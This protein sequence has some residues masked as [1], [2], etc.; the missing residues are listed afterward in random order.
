MPFRVYI[1]M[2][3]M[4]SNLLPVFLATGYLVAYCILLRAEPAIATIMLLFSP[5]VVC[6]MVYS[7]LKFARY[8]GTDLGDEEYGYQDKKKEEL[9]TF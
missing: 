6:G 4:R 9:G 1:K 5:L 8:K 3:V 2:N 7:V